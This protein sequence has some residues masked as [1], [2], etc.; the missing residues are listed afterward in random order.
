M[1][2]ALLRLPLVSF[3][4]DGY[5]RIAVDDVGAFYPA[6]EGHT[7]LD[8]KGCSEGGS[9]RISLPAAEVERLVI[10]AMEAIARNG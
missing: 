9:F 8:R 7:W 6:S 4:G 5:L 1:T 3:T 10:E 2:I